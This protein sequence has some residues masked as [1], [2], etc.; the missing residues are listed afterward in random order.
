MKKRPKRNGLHLYFIPHAYNDY[1]P[2]L[3]GLS[4]VLILI[5]TIVAL[6][7]VVEFAVKESLAIEGQ[8]A[9]VVESSLYTLANGDRSSNGKTGLTYSAVLSYAAQLKAEDMAKRHYFSHN[10]PQGIEPWVW[11]DKV[12]Y[13]YENAGENFPEPTRCVLQSRRPDYGHD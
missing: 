7:Y 6:P 12:G 9:A 5:V 8:T 11:F 1:H 13:Q 3:L 10:D 2:H 4:S